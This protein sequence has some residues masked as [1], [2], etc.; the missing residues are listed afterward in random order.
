MHSHIDILE[1]GISYANL[2]LEL[3]LYIYFSENEVL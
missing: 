3:V 1:K 2:M